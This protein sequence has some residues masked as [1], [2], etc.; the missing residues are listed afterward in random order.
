MAIEAVRR[1]VSNRTFKSTFYLVGGWERPKKRRKA[2]EWITAEFCI[3]SFP[4]C[5]W[6]WQRKVERRKRIGP[7]IILRRKTRRAKRDVARRGQKI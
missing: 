3:L 5:G 7:G 6:G 2:R 1:I 4:L